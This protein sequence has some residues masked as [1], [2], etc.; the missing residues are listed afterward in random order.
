MIEPDMAV[1]VCNVLHERDEARRQIKRA[2]DALCH[3]LHSADTLSPQEFINV[4]ANGLGVARHEYV[5]E[6]NPN[7]SLVEW[8][9]AERAT[10][11]QAEP[12]PLG[13][14]V[15]AGNDLHSALNPLITLDPREVAKRRKHWKRVVAALEVLRKK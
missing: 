15:D 6:C 13:L 4:C 8:H 1:E 11:S 5:G 12:P 10:S 14:L 7:K 2:E 9:I 3:I